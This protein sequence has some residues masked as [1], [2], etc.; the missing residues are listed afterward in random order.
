MFL[1]HRVDT[2]LHTRGCFSCVVF[3]HAIGMNQVQLGARDPI[4]QLRIGGRALPVHAFQQV[5]LHCKY[6][7]HFS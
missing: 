1:I 3:L 6:L 5:H 7:Q 4:K 2:V